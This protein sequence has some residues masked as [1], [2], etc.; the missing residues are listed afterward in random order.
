ML[1]AGGMVDH[2][3]HRRR[4]RHTTTGTVAGH[5]RRCVERAGRPGRRVRCHVSGLAV[6]GC[7]HPARHHRLGGGHLAGP[8][9]LP[10]DRADRD[11]VRHP[12]R[13][14]PGAVP[15]GVPTPRHGD[16]AGP[17]PP[18]PGPGRVGAGRHPAAPGGGHR[19]GPVAAV[20]ERDR[21][22]RPAAVRQNPH[23]PDPQGPRRLRPGCWSPPPSSTCSCSPPPPGNAPAPP[24]IC[25]T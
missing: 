8:D 14:R 16:P 13:C 18:W 7:H 5:R 6:L 1:V 20:G 23:R 4:T 21:G 25:S 3:A 12:G 22:D 10:A 17:D 15:D 9:V 2:P 24:S 11:R 19:P